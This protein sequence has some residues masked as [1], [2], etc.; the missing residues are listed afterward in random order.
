VARHLRTIL[1]LLLL[2]GTAAAFVVTEE[3]KLEPDPIARPRITPVF[4]PTCR[5]DTQTAQIAFRLRQ[6]DRL[7]LEIHDEQGRVVRTLLRTT[8]FGRGNH[9][10]GWDG[11][12]DNGRPVPEG[13]YRPRIELDKLNRAIEFPREIR[14]DTTPARL[15][16]TR[17]R[18]RRISP[19]GDGRADTVTMRYRASEPVHAILL[20][21][22]RQE[23]KTALRRSG[24]LVWSPRG[25][26]RGS[27]RLSVA[28]VDEA[29]NRSRPT[30]SYDVRVRYVDIAAEVIRARPRAGFSVRVST[31]ARRYFWRLGRRTGSA[32]VRILRLR[33]PA[34]PGR[35]PL[36]VEVFE[37]RDSATVVVRRP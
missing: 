16:V 37:R 30:Q 1:V 28:A 25:R 29:G 11:R 5:C 6:P 31:D 27:Y 15:E 20:V 24:A 35:Y 8:E 32:R 33:A 3:L 4:S 14:V 36:V 26:R 23:V 2:A 9:A 22:G 10:F 21:N 7:T 19:D 12:D 18:P 13:S 34:Q 17:L